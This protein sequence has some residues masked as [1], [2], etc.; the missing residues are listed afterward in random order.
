[1]PPTNVSTM[2]L[3][4]LL[5]CMA[6]ILLTVSIGQQNTLTSWLAVKH[7]LRATAGPTLTLSLHLCLKSSK[8]VPQSISPQL[9][10]PARSRASERPLVL[11]PLY[12][13]LFDLLKWPM[14]NPVLSSTRANGCLFWI[15]LSCC[16]LI[17][18]VRKQSK[19]N[20]ILLPKRPAS[21]LVLTTLLS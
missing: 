3:K 19:A 7:T 2:F 18:S 4:L 20:L 16:S 1:M 15:S 13:L 17:Q 5:K 8:T 6:C 10:S 11:H 21:L 9:P 14:L 12:Q